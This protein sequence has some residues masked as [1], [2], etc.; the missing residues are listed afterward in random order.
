MEKGTNKLAYTFGKGFTEPPNW[1]E[2]KISGKPYISWGDKNLM[3]EYLISLKE[4]SGTHNA[5]LQKRSL[6]TYGNGLA[7]GQEIPQFKLGEKETLKAIIDDYWLYGMWAMNV[8][9]SKDGR[10]IAHAEHIDMSKLRAGKKNPLG[11]IEDWFFSNDWKNY[12]KQENKPVPK[13]AYDPRNPIGS[14]IFVYRGYSSGCSFYSKPSYYGAAN[15]MALDYE[16]SNFHLNN[17]QNGFAPSMMITMH[18]MPDSQEERDYIYESLKKQYQGTSNAGEIF[19]MF[20]RDKENGIEVTP[21][22]ANDSDT[23]YKDLMGIVQDQILIGHSVVSPILY[24][25]KTP[26]QLGGSN[27]LA[28][29]FEI[30]MS[31]EIDPVQ[32]QIGETLQNVLKLDFQPEFVD[33]SPVSFAFSESVMEKILTQNELRDLISYEPLAES[34]S[35]IEEDSIDNENNTI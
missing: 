12:R 13:K 22:N 31:T 7:E 35:T 11:K 25:I 1:T 21:I 8:V 5:I 3:P 10:S 27:E 9:W 30:T 29:S 15:Y 4:N 19:L 18:D 14:Q 33:S 28:T 17:A 6:Y 2:F 20:A 32:K 24:G 16:I 23:R 34:E 26:G